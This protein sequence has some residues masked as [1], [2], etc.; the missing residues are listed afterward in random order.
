[1]KRLSFKNMFVIGLLPFIV[2]A[3]K[4]DEGPALAQVP[5]NLL[6]KADAGKDQT[7]IYPLNK[8][9][10]TGKGVDMDGT[11]ISYHWE[12][13]S[14]PSSFS[15]ISPQEASTKVQNLVAGNYVFT[16]QVTDNSG[17]SDI[18]RVNV[19]VTGYTDPNDPGL[20]SWDY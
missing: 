8:V 4:K 14:G 17:G 11:I 7:V 16:L 10:L 6:P 19:R 1:M 9:Q 5:N 15:I 20:G 3:C 18:A 2:F 13:L 12:K